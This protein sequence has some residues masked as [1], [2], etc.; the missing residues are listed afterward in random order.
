LAWEGATGPGRADA[1]LQSLNANRT[2]EA[3]KAAHQTGCKKFIA[4]GTVYENFYLQMDDAP[5]FF[6]AAF[7]IM[8]KRYARDMARQM[9]LKLGIGFT[10][11]TFCHPVGKYIKPEQLI[12]SAVKKLLD[13]VSPAF[14]P[15][16][17][18]FDIIA[19]ED[20]A[21]GLYLAGAKNLPDCEYY[22]GSG[23][24][25]PLKDYLLK[26]PQILGVDTEIG[27]GVNPDDGMR[28]DKT[29]FDAKPFENASGFNPAVSFEK[30]V[31]GLKENLI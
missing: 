19:V 16:A 26:I 4:T 5:Q 17:D 14:G 18:Y 2:M 1:V 12:A 7:Y 24:A 21:A 8:S 15:A 25:G 30:I 31:L 23:E 11:C 22:I 13:G 29:W 9:A 27:I 28:F 20:L 6:N 3:I 10:W